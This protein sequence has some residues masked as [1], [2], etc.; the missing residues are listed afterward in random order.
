[1]SSQ[2]DPNSSG[3]HE[4]VCPQCKIRRVYVK[5]GDPA[6]PCPTC[7]PPPQDL[8]MSEGYNDGRR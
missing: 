1:M 5:I 7:A 4:Q 3:Y 2:T 8:R 6:R